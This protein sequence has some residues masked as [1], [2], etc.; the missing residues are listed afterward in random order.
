MENFKKLIL[1]GLIV[2]TPVFSFANVNEETPE[3]KPVNINT[4]KLPEDQPLKPDFKFDDEDPQGRIRTG[5]AIIGAV[6]GVIGGSSGGLIGIGTGFIAGT[7]AGDNFGSALEAG[8]TYITGDDYTKWSVDAPKNIQ[9]LKKK[10]EF[11]KESDRL[12]EIIKDK[13]KQNELLGINGNE[14]SKKYVNIEK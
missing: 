7:V 2:A 5:A 4:P 6:V 9:E 3:I 12:G 1:L 13:N 14:K 8:L 11:K 10:D